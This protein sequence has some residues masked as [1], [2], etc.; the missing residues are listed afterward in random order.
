MAFGIPNR[1][2]VTEN[3]KD[4]LDSRFAFEERGIVDIKGK[5]LMN[6]YFLE[7]RVD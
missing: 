5:G 6:L 7:G 2:Q 3:V 4:A 1:I